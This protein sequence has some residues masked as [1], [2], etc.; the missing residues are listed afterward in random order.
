MVVHTF[1]ILLRIGNI[2]NTG[3]RWTRSTDKPNMDKSY[4]D[5]WSTDKHS[6]R[7]S[8]YG[9]NLYGTYLLWDKPYMGH[10]LYKKNA[11]WNKPSTGHLLNKILYNFQ[12]YNH[13]I[14]SNLTTGSQSILCSNDKKYWIICSLGIDWIIS[15]EGLIIWKITQTS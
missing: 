9:T 14:F 1:L 2:K 15:H 5:K 13:L 7:Q 6:M 8:L 4:M 11:G 3:I 10:N 12:K